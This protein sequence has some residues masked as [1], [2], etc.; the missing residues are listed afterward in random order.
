MREVLA[1]KIKHYFVHLGKNKQITKIRLKDKS[2]LD[3]ALLSE[4]IV[5]KI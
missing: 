4:K 3:E 5:L 2:M 1:D